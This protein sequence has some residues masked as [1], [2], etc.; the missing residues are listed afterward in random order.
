MIGSFDRLGF[1]RHRRRFRDGDLDEDLS[2]VTAI[3]TGANSGLGYATASGLAARGATVLLVCRDAGRGEAA[4]DRIRAATGS[5]SIDL[6]VVDVSDLDAVRSFVRGL[7][8]SR[9][10]RLV[11]NAGLLPEFRT[12][13]RQGHE[14]TFA[15]HVLGAH[16]LTS[17]LRARLLAS[18][19]ARVVFVSSGGMYTER[20]SLDDITWARRT[21]DGVRAYAQTKR[22]QV[23]LAEA[24][25][26]ELEGTAV[27]VYSMH[28]GWADTPGVLRSL[29][30]FHRLTAPLLRTPEQ[31]AD[32]V[33]WLCTVARPPAPRGAFFFDREPQRTHLLPW[34]RDT[35]EG[36]DLFW[37]TCEIS[38]D[39]GDDDGD[40][41]AR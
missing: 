19:D 24:W 39:G 32:T 25:A 38:I 27:S 12:L 37:R 21:Y 40:Q 6:A 16:A 8:W 11:H 17:G 35:A 9:V 15:T 2:S 22:M 33:L 7:S 4:R 20:L 18:H 13:T 34:T 28:P 36:R 29:P 41:R 30:R 26:R 31:G 3:V 5:R 23:V 14:L 1:E 10:D